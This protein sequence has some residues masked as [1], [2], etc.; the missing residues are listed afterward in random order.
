MNQLDKQYNLTVSLP[1]ADRTGP[2]KGD[3]GFVD[4]R[5]EP[6]ESARFWRFTTA[7]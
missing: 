6:G 3:Q 5:A 4:L 2:L 1:F 7:L